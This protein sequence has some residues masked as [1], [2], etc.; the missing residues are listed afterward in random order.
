MRNEFYWRKDYFELLRETAEWASGDERLRM[1][2]EYCVLT[3]KGLRKQGLAAARAFV[4]ETEDWTDDERRTV[5]NEICERGH[6]HAWV[7]ALS[8]HPIMKGLIWPT[9]EA[10]CEE[11]PASSVPFRWLGM[12]SRDTGPLERAIAK[13][14]SDQIALNSLLN[15][16]IR[17]V[18]FS[19]HHLPEG[20]IGDPGIDLRLLDRAEELVPLV[21]DLTDRERWKNEVIGYRGLV[22]SYRDFRREV[23]SDGFEGW[24][25][26]SGRPYSYRD[27]PD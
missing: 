6:R 9:L 13:D 12:M 24:A 21:T 19:V 20:Y 16:L 15:K 8:P 7:G 25:L 27:L 17:A 5:V 14:P 3:E 1:F 22:E 11:D 2:Y 23:A 10:W 4:A 26:R 18:D